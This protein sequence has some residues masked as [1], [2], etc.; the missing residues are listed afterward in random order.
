MIGNAAPAGTLLA[1]NTVFN[2]LGQ[3]VP[4]IAA[5]VLVPFIVHGL[6]VARFGILSLAWVVLAYLT[7]FDLGLGRA[8]IRFVSAHLA[9]DKPETIPGLFWTSLVLQ[10]GVA[11]V[12]GLAL[13]AATPALVG[14]LLHV[15]A[16]LTGE[17][18][19]AFYVLA[20]LA[21]ISVPTASVRG[22]LEA[23]QRFD[24]VNAVKSVSNSMVF[25]A[26]AVGVVVGLH[27]DGIM[28][29]LAISIVATL[30]VY[31][32][33]AVRIWP[34]LGRGFVWERTLARP[35]FSFGSWVLVSGV[36]VPGLIYADRFMISAIAGVSVLAFY[37]VPYEIVAR[38]QIIPTSFGTVLFPAF[39]KLSQG[40]RADITALFANSVKY[41]LLL[42]GPAALLLALLAHPI[43]QYWVGLEFALKGTLVLQLLA[44]GVVLNSLAQLSAQIIDA[45][46]RPDL[47]AKM[48]LAYL[49]PYL[50]FAWFMIQAY[51]VVGAAA[52]WAIRGAFDLAISTTVAWILTPF[53]ARSV[54]QPSLLRAA[55]SFAVFGAGGA[56]IILLARVGTLS[57]Y[58]LAAACVA[59]SA[60]VLWLYALDRS[61][62]GKVR[63]VVTSLMHPGGAG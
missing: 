10:V 54:F 16:S 51:G 5:L 46:G 36:L 53:D 8:T 23:N 50:V 29:L 24:L 61:E 21:P 22:F 6:G 47:R 56:A 15:P 49:P 27:L 32:W 20:V 40:R 52:A 57:F 42:I 30:L 4:G 13:A 35:L 17:T 43:L 58:A 39:S 55:G 34:P 48:F 9:Q 37:T 31:L 7:L 14:G 18:E 25:I 12:G 38:L 41:M 59:A 63:A 28:A 11:S 3:V 2:F 62:R 60:G 33:L 45:V 26:P 19:R 1:R 44:I